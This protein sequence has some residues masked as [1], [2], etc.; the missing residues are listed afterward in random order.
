M[1]NIFIQGKQCFSIKI[2]TIHTDN[3]EQ[4]FFTLPQQQAKSHSIRQ[5]C[6]HIIHILFCHIV[7]EQFFFVAVIVVH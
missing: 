1:L 7:H 6:R 2:K 3:N 4:A 5:K